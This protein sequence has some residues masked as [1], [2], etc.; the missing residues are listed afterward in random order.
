LRRI[1]VAE[2]CTMHEHNHD[3]H[4]HAHRLDI[5]QVNTSLIAGICLNIL[6]V[7]V[8]FGAGF[9]SNSLALISDAGHNLSDVASLALALLAFKLL[10]IKPTEKFTY[11]YRKASILIS[12]LNAVILLIAVGSIGYES[13]HRFLE[14][15]PV[16]SNVVISVAA[17]GIVIN[18]VSALFFFRDRKK[19]LNLKGAYLH[20]MVDA[21]VSLGVVVAGIIMAYTQWLWIDP[22]ISVVIMIVILASTWNLLSDSLSLSMDA[23]PTNISIENIREAALKLSGIRD[24]HHIHV[25][26]I[27]TAENALTAHLVISH[28]TSQEETSALKN[29]LKHEL[30]HM[31]IQHATLET[32]VEGSKENITKAHA[33]CK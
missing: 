17:I 24:I 2:F 26:A 14:P 18:A 3:H 25:W 21:L 30:E 29:R 8:E 10:K 5:N 23:V 9:F 11:G 16:A 22:L 33:D 32:E 7:V 31:G 19:D 13:V 15:K 1:F 12:L 6:F 4:H 27:S 28:S 20:L